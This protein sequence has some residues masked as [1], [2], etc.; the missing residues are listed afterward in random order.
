MCTIFLLLGDVLSFSLFP[1]SRLSLI[2]YCTDSGCQVTWNFLWMCL[3]FSSCYTWH[4]NNEGANS[5]CPPGF[6]TFH[7]LT[8]RPHFSLIAFWSMLFIYPIV[9]S[10]PFHLSFL[11]PVLLLLHVKSVPSPPVFCSCIL[12]MPLSPYL[13]SPLVIP[14]PISY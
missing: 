5:F 6:H 8:S 14:L 9:I 12:F 4:A 1:S 2:C 7:T 13:L 11:P 10:S 3:G